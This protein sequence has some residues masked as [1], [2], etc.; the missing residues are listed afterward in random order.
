MP[1]LIAPQPG[2]A[3]KPDPN[4]GRIVLFF[5]GL[6]LAGVLIYS[7]YTLIRAAQAP[8]PDPDVTSADAGAATAR[9]A[10]PTPATMSSLPAGAPPPLMT[11]AAP[12]PRDAP[13][14]A[15]QP[16]VPKPER[17]LTD[18][19]IIREREEVARQTIE[20]LRQQA[21]D[22]PHDENAMSEE[23]LKALEK[24]GAMVM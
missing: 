17:E 6:V 19:R 2:K 7:A 11:D 10:P 23:R 12:P 13:L 3:P 9:N 22:N 1:L 21:R 5:V 20:T 16:I 15:A 4:E 18:Y 8:L 24:S 14:P